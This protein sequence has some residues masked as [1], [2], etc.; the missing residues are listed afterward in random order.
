M[1]DP[2]YHGNSLNGNNLTGA[3]ANAPVAGRWFQAAFVQLVKNAWP[4]LE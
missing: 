2:E 4:P 1:C 3:L